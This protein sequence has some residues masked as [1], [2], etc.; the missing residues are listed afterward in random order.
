MSSPGRTDREPADELRRLEEKVKSQQSELRAVQQALHQSQHWLSF[1]LDAAQFVA[2]EWEPRA[3]RMRRYGDTLTVWGVPPDL[4][5]GT[6]G[7]FLRHVREGFRDRVE[8][9]MRFWSAP[10][11]EIEFPIVSPSDG[12]E[13]W[14]LDRHRRQ[15][16]AECHVERIYGIS[17][18]I[19]LRRRWEQQL[20]QVNTVLEEVAAERAVLA[21]ERLAQ[22]RQ[23]ALELSEAEQRERNRLAA[24]LHDHMQ[25]LMV[26]ARMRVDAALQGGGEARRHMLQARSILDHCMQEAR[27]LAVELNPPV[28]TDAGLAAALRWLAKWMQ[29][30]YGFFVHVQADSVDDPLSP[31][32][33]SFMFQSVREL[34]LNAVKHSGVREGRVTMATAEGDQLVVQVA[35]QGRGFP[36]ESAKQAARPD[37]FGLFSIQERLRVLGGSI[38][39]ITAPGKGTDVR[40]RAPRSREVSPPPPGPQA[41]PSPRLASERPPLRIVV[42]DD[43]AMVREGLA[44]V[45]DR[46][47]DMQVIGAAADGQSGVE[48]ASELHPDVVVMD[49][50]MPVMNGMEATR[51]IAMRQPSVRIIGVSL[52]DDPQIIQRMR[53]A[54]AVDYV[55]KSSDPMQLIRAIRGGQ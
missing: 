20:Q 51:Y 41:P 50:N 25:Q 43:H 16:D 1:A 2:W 12:A 19:T 53:D 18:D 36:P 40:L 44:Q 14:I 24:V 28:L 6:A 9:S 15:Y 55:C 11:S 39:M 37:G 32:V 26:A 42:V 3:D 54:G 47:P 33:A 52:H 30:H 38:E 22:V 29:E 7:S 5:D 8:Q 13:R 31:T 34:L 45:I 10:G 48:L 4:L 17:M 21:D 35:D 23:M 49:V 46:E 27:T